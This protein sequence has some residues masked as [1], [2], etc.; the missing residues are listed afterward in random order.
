M[1]HLIGIGYKKENLSYDMLEIIKTADEVFLEYYTSF[2]Q[3]SFEELLEKKLQYVI[4]KLSKHKL[5][6][7]Y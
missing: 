7:K 2:Y 3:N 4:E 6:I 5:K 1:L